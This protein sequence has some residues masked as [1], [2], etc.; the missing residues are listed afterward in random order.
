M[1]NATQPQETGGMNGMAANTDSANRSQLF[2]NCAHS[3]ALTAHTDC[4]AD[5]DSLPQMCTMP[6][7]PRG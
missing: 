5:P 1:Q 3:H 6:Q 2:E 7:K 4:R